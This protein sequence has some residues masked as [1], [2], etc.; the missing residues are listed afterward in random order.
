MKTEISSKEPFPWMTPDLAQIDNDQILEDNPKIDSYP[1]MTTR[2]NGDQKGETTDWNDWISEDYQD[3]SYNQTKHKEFTTT[4]TPEGTQQPERM[5]MVRDTEEGHDK[6][7][8]GGGWLITKGSNTNTTMRNVDKTNAKEEDDHKKLSLASQ[9]NSLPHEPHNGHIT[10]NNQK[11]DSY[12]TRKTGGN[13]DQ[14]DGSSDWNDWISKDDKDNE[15]SLTRYRESTTTWISASTPQQEFSMITTGTSKNKPEE[16]VSHDKK[17]SRDIHADTPTTYRVMQLDYG[18]I[19]CKIS[20]PA[21]TLKQTTGKMYSATYPNQT[22]HD[23]GKQDAVGAKFEGYWYALVQKNLVSNEQASRL[24]QKCH[25]MANSYTFQMFTYAILI[26]A[27]LI[28]TAARLPEETSALRMPYLFRPLIYIDVCKANFLISLDIT[29]D[30]NAFTSGFPNSGQQNNYKQ[31]TQMVPA[32]VRGSNPKQNQVGFHHLPIRVEGSN[33]IKPQQ[34]Q[35]GSVCVQ[36]EPRTVQA[37]CLDQ[38]SQPYAFQTLILNI[39]SS[40]P[41]INKVNIEGQQQLYKHELEICTIQ[42]LLTDMINNLRFED[43][44]AN[45]LIFTWNQSEYGFLRIIRCRDR[46]TCSDE[47]NSLHGYPTASSFEGED[48][49]ID[50]N[51]Q[52]YYEC[53]ADWTEKGEENIADLTKE[54]AENNNINSMGLG[55]L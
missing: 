23:S 34:N 8:Q 30:D 39:N 42:H 51:N 29:P 35:E 55:H 7:L 14:E 13:Y 45:R 19:E 10:R 27:L 37:P 46:G 38:I 33:P 4:W 12:L 26:L 52:E 28:N 9:T 25:I 44:F 40:T 22:I 41:N 54:E 21:T 6:K 47:N 49:Q 15:F 18:K 11:T 53:I 2:E 3:N 20:Q 1:T 36:T 24:D 32:Q 17:P 16:E 31:M 5:V 48:H 43:S 50:P